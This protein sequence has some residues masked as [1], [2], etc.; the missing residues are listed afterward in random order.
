MEGDEEMRVT[1]RFFLYLGEACV[2]K[3]KRCCAVQDAEEMKK[4]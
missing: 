3:I 2:Q 4:K 1:D